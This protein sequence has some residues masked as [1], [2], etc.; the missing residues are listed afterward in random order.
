MVKINWTLCT[1]RWWG[2]KNFLIFPSF[3]VL[4]L[5]LAVLQATW[6]K[7]Y[8]LIFSNRFLCFCTHVSSLGVD[9][10]TCTFHHCCWWCVHSCSVT[11]SSG[12]Y[13]TLLIVLL[14]SISDIFKQWFT[15]YLSSDRWRVLPYLL[16][17]FYESSVSWCF[18]LQIHLHLA[19]TLL[20]P[21]WKGSCIPG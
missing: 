20:L 1:H 9:T 5:V 17:H 15:Q 2:C 6:W 10:T 8:Y 13:S 4:S 3:W 7:F 11:T 12:F 16:V 18:W 19:L 14:I 21:G